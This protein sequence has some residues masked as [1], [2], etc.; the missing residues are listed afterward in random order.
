MY[1]HAIVSKSHIFG[2]IQ[3]E[4][5]YRA[6]TCMVHVRPSVKG[7]GATGLDLPSRASVL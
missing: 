5:L 6:L 4:T 2:V 7:G 1:L 3:L